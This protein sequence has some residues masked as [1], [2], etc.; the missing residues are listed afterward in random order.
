[1]AQYGAILDSKSGGALCLKSEVEKRR[2]TGAVD[3][4]FLRQVRA[5]HAVRDQESLLA[6]HPAEYHELHYLDG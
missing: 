5:G 1:M 6:H 2:L 4:E 3:A